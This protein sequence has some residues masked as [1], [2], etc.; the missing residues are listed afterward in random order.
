[1][2]VRVVSQSFYK[3]KHGSLTSQSK[4]QKCFLPVF[5]EMSQ[6]FSVARLS[7]LQFLVLALAYLL[8]KCVAHELLVSYFS[9][10]LSLLEKYPAKQAALVRESETRGIEFR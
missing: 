1:M 10:R 7:R 2:R 8:L 6:F 4:L 5:R 9:F 3:S